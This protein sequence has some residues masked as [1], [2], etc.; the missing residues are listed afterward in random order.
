MK[1]I[2][3]YLFVLKKEKGISVIALIVA[4]LLLGSIGIIMS[5]LMVRS[6]ESIPRGLD[7]S[8]A[9]YLV[10][11]GVEFTGKYLQGVSDW[12]TLSGT[13]TRNLG[14]GSFQ[15]QWGAYDSGTQTIN[16]TI[17]GTSGS[18]RRQVTAAL[19]KSGTSQGVSSQGG[20]N[21]YNSSSFNCGSS[22]SPCTYTNVPSSN[23][24]VISRPGGLSAPPF[25][26]NLSGSSTYT[27]S[28]GTYYCSSF[29]VAN[30]VQISVSGPVTLFCGGLTMANSSRFNSGGSAANLLVISSGSVS[31]WNSSQFRGAVYAPGQSINLGNSTQFTG[32][33]AGGSPTNSINFYNSATFDNSAGS[34][35]PYF[36]QTG[37]GSATI[38]LTGWQE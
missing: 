11:A 34:S 2:L 21:F 10:Q 16:V 6:Q 26:C 4:I 13:L 1:K 27:L 32:T 3:S 19:Q 28:A 7:T 31:F 20:I 9:L 38:G 5:S 8:R 36:N 25:G 15:I 17:Q 12:S 14:T 22:P 24:P 35:S 18:A 33:I 37:G 23:M 30:S 29:S